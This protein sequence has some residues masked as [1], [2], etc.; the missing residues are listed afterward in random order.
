MY[1][2][3]ADNDFT[4]AGPLVTVILMCTGCILTT[5]LLVYAGSIESNVALALDIGSIVLG[6]VLLETISR[7]GSGLNL[8]LSNLPG[9]YAFFY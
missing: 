5:L 3:Y 4:S 6:A 7:D 9:L 8:S 1:S 2:R